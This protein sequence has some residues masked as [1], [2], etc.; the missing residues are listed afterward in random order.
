MMMNRYSM[1]NKDYK[2]KEQHEY[3]LNMII[4]VVGSCQRLFFTGKK[5][6]FFV[7]F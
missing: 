5:T 7:K 4:S 3:N 1:N 2:W 6:F